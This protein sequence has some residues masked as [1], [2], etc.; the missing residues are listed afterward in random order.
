MKLRN[1]W[2]KW[3]YKRTRITLWKLKARWMIMDAIDTPIQ[4]FL[5][6]F[7][8]SFNELLDLFIIA[9]FH[10]L[11]LLP[12]KR[13]Y[14]FLFLILRGYQGHSRGKL[15]VTYKKGFKTLI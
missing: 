1:T 4:R 3:K 15:K 12:S 14:I 7:Y 13:C 5:D 9:Y 8:Q 2:G 11:L 10:T 6:K